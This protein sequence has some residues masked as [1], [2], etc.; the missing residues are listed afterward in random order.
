MNLDLSV[1]LTEL[2]VLR[3]CKQSAVPSGLHGAFYRVLFVLTL[4]ALHVRILY[5]AYLWASF[6]AAAIR[7]NSGHPML[8][9][10]DKLFVSP[11]PQHEV[12]WCVDGHS[13]H[14]SVRCT[15]KECPTAPE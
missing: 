10:L 2:I 7:V 6:A 15:S 4:F 8:P 1:E 9:P 14:V 12:S 11:D 5:L 3:I 13:I